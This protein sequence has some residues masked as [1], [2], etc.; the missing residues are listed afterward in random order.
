MIFV[1]KSKYDNS[2]YQ[3]NC[4]LKENDNKNWLNMFNF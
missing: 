4:Y 3:R 2:F 1:K